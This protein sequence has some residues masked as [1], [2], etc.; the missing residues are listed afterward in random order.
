MYK[1]S[2]LLK[3]HFVRLLHDLFGLL[4]PLSKAHLIA[5][6]LTDCLEEGGVVQKYKYSREVQ[7]FL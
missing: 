6:L 2:T 3:S 4:W 5:L 7:V 1:F